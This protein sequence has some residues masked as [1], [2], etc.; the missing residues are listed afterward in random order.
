MDYFESICKMLLE[1]H[2]YWVKQSYKVDLSKEEKKQLGKPSLP[3]PEIDLLALN[4]KKN[5]LLI[6]EVKSYF[7]SKGVRLKD[8]QNI[9]SYPQGKFN[10]FTCEPYRKI[11]EARVKKKLFDDG[12]IPEDISIKLGLIFGKVVASDGEKI[13]KLCNERGWFYWAPDEIRN[14]VEGLVS[15]GYENEPCIITTKILRR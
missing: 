11:I 4:V 3:R 5:E 10:L 13:K 6:I 2:G 12:L 1:D 15:K 8:L 9:Q 14:K 7:D